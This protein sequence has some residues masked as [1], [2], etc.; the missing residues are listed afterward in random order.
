MVNYFENCLYSWCVEFLKLC[1]F[2]PLTPS[3]FQ[4]TFDA[5][6]IQWKIFNLLYIN[7]FETFYIFQKCITLLT[8]KYWISNNMKQMCVLPS[9][10]RS[11]M[12]TD[13]HNL[14]TVQLSIKALHQSSAPEM[15]S[16]GYPMNKQDTFWCIASRWP[17]MFCCSLLF[18]CRKVVVKQHLLLLWITHV[19]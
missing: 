6:N 16:V 3:Y 2:W 9:I 13:I 17:H 12:Y 4:F 7:I 18:S 8:G 1:D 11:A 19:T 14:W 5:I 15:A 10:Y